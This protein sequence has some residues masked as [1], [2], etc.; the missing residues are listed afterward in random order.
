M[1]PRRFSPVFSRVK[2]FLES[3]QPSLKLVERAEIQISRTGVF[4][5]ITNLASSGSSKITSS[6]PASPST[7][8]PCAS[9]RVSRRFLRFSNAASAF[10][11]KSFSSSMDSAYTSEFS[12]A[13]EGNDAA[14]RQKGDEKPE[15]GSVGGIPQSFLGSGD[16]RRTENDERARGAHMHKLAKEDAARIGIEPGDEHAHGGHRGSEGDEK[17]KPVRAV[18]GRRP[19][20]IDNR[21]VPDAP[22]KTEQHG[23]GESRELLTHFRENETHPADLFEKAGG[24]SE[25]D[26]D[27]KRGWTVDRGDQ[28]FQT[29]KNGE[30]HGLG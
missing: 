22:Q 28:R 20:E 1:T 30:Y 3:D 21:Q 26:A 29:Q 27:K 2:A 17:R 18:R 24:N 12:R 15:G 9:P 11:W 7:S 10:R 25:C 4:G 16:A 5:E 14:A 23:R 13:R 8:K 19:Q 6:F